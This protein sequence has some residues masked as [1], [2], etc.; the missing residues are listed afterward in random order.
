MTQALE[1]ILNFRDRVLGDENMAMAFEIVPPPCDMPEDKI[2]SRTEKMFSVIS[3][4]MD[5]I[6]A[7][8]LPDIDENELG[9]DGTKRIRK[10]VMDPRH[11]AK[12]LREQM[13]SLELVLN[14]RT[15]KATLRENEEYLKN[16]AEHGIFNIIPVGGDS[17]SSLYPGISPLKFADIISNLN[18]NE[19]KYFLG[20]ICIPSRG[21]IPRNGKYSVSNYNLEPSKLVE[22]QSK[23]IQYFT[24]Q[25]QYKTD[26]LF[27]MWQR[28]R[29]KCA[30]QGVE[31]SRILVGVSPILDYENFSFLKWL[32]VDIGE[33]IANYIFS[34]EQKTAE[35][36]IKIIDYELRKFFDHVY[37]IDGKAKFG[38]YVECTS[39]KGLSA[40]VELL[41]KSKGIAADYG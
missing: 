27:E 2:L 24:T 3:N 41:G 5:S 31:P 9:S 37:G 20:G 15:V 29:K 10:P 19:A 14:R 17:G 40:S 35:R 11:Y 7:F 18:G 32:G 16:M 6:D 36:S 38:I 13:P 1:K 33:E 21:I 8:I 34:G 39:P 30:G 23:G 25:I 4:E 12:I 28:Y 22:K 26:N